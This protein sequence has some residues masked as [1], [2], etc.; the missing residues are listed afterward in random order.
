MIAQRPL[1]HERELACLEQM[2]QQD[3]LPHALLFVG[4]AGIGKKLVA[5][6]LAQQLLCS[7]TTDKPCG[8]CESCRLFAAASHPDFFLLEPEAK[9]NAQIKIDQIRK[10]QAQL[11]LAPCIGSRRVVIIDKAEQLNA[12]AA[13]SLL[14]TL[15][16]PVGDICF[17]LIAQNTS[18][19][20]PTIVSRCTKITFAPLSTAALVQILQEHY[21]EI[22][23]AQAMVIAKTAFGSARQALLSYQPEKRKLRDL[24]FEIWQNILSFDDVQLRQQADQL[25]ALES[26]DLEQCIFYL[27]LLWRDQAAGT[28]FYNLD[29]AAQFAENVLQWP[30]TRSFQ[31]FDYSLRLQQKLRSN[32]NVKLA[33]ECFLLQVRRLSAR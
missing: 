13:N 4:Q 31:A 6:Y 7:A 19:L 8:T 26:E 3:D 28:F 14:K 20:L 25:A 15:E 17:I 2:C 29:W 23:S 30:P 9:K 16:E 24:S 12:A 1:G 32:V 5:L 22:P 27:Q 10:L 11:A 21:S 33:I 18:Q